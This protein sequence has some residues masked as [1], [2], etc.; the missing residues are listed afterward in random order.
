[1]NSV[2]KHRAF[3]YG[4][5][6]AGVYAHSIVSALNIRQLANDPASDLDEER[7][8]TLLEALQKQKGL[9]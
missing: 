3:W 2:V 9:P 4:R 8:A 6:V 1:M 5:V 7:L